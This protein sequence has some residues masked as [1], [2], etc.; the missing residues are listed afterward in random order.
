MKKRMI[1]KRLTLQKRTIAN[2]GDGFMGTLKGGSPNTRETCGF[3]DSVISCL[4]TECTIC[5]SM[6]ETLCD[7]M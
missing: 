7:C 2:I 6:P 5:M 1:T 3:C 4:E